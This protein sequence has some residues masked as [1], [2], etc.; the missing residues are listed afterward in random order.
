MPSPIGHTLPLKLD[1]HGWITARPSAIFL[2]IQRIQR[3]L[4]GPSSQVRRTCT[5]LV[6]ID[7]V[8]C[9]FPYKPIPKVSKVCRSPSLIVLP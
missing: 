1:K 5:F 4:F 9:P 3:T 8:D 2:R 6:P 7:A